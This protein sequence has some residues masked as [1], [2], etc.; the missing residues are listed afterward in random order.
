MATMSYGDYR[1]M[2]EDS[3]VRTAL[4]EFRE[5]EGELVAVSLIDRLDDGVSAVYSFYDPTRERLSLGTWSILW[6]VGECR[7]HGLPSFYPRYL[8]AGK[9]KVAHKAPLPAPRRLA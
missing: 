2:V 6:L 7:Q 9:P 4:V 1:S 8:V 5:A 3:A